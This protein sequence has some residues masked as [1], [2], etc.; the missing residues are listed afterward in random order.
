[1]LIR[2][3]LVLVPGCMHVTHVTKPRTMM[4]STRLKRGRQ[5]PP[6][7]AGDV[8]LIPFDTRDHRCVIISNV[9]GSYDQWNVKWEDGSVGTQRLT[10][11]GARRLESATN[12][13]ATPAA[14]VGAERIEKRKRPRGAIKCE[15]ESEGTS[16]LKLKLE[17]KSKS[18]S[19]TTSKDDYETRRET[20][21]PDLT[22]EPELC[23]LL[24]VR[25]LY[26][27]PRF[28]CLQPPGLVD[29]TQRPIVQDEL[30]SLLLEKVRGG[31]CCWSSQH[32]QR[33]HH[34]ATIHPDLHHRQPR[35]IHP[36]QPHNRRRRPARV[37]GAAR[38]PRTN[39]HGIQTGRALL[40]CARQACCERK[41]RR[42]E[43][44]DARPPDHQ[45]R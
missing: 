7:A 2:A 43:A 20:L 14:N 22:L 33:H 12:S 28:E 38:L 16:K 36:S 27:D 45:T 3:D 35:T 34:Y 13:T 42:A 31:R 5:S 15:I 23:R 18:K 17:R 4:T 1:M 44:G 29:G 11:R 19:K 37:P 30:D 26:E 41:C 21:N 25:G 24:G 10:S 40:V 6:P 9:D 39:A 32:Y 8:W